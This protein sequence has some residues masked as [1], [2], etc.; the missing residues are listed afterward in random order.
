MDDAFAGA[1]PSI[2]SAV[3]IDAK[4]NG[5][6]TSAWLKDATSPQKSTNTPLLQVGLTGSDPNSWCNL[7][8]TGFVLNSAGFSNPQYDALCAKAAKTFNSAKAAKLYQEAGHIALSQA[9]YIPIGQ[10]QQFAITKVSGVVGD[11]DWVQLEPKDFD[12]ANI[13]VK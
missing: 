10:V 5:I 9:T 13:T 7:R 12:W 8:V 11:P 1:I 6:P 2:L 3:G 4:G